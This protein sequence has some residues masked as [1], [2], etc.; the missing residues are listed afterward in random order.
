MGKY[1][2]LRIQIISYMKLPTRIF[3]ASV[4]LVI[5]FGC[6][7]TTPPDVVAVNLFNAITSG[8][9]E[10]VK[11]NIWFSQESD[12]KAVNDF[13]DIVVASSDYKQRTEGYTADYRAVRV[14]YEGDEA[15]VELQGRNVIGERIITLV[16]LL[17]I[18]ER[19]MVNGEQSVFDLPAEIQRSK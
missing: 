14:N 15:W 8:N 6:T 3:F 7:R 4:L 16:H 11:E 19:W 2:Y 10:Y 1:C 17:Y 9:V 5:I 18:N 12:Y 13:L